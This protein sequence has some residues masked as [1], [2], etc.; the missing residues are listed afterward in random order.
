[1]LQ[2]AHI[3]LPVHLLLWLLHLRLGAWLL[4]ANRWQLHAMRSLR[5]H[6]EL[7]ELRWKKLTDADR[8]RT[9]S[10]ELMR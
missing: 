3:R 10:N 8:I 4:L 1:M 9:C 6:E 2:I 5:I 7:R